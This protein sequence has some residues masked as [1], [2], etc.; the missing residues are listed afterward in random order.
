MS[1]NI[2]TSS[3]TS[4]LPILGLTIDQ[5]NQLM[6]LLKSNSLN[7]ANHTSKKNLL[8][9]TWIANSKASNHM[10]ELETLLDDI[11]PIYNHTPINIPNGNEFHVI[12]VGSTTF[13]IS[14][15]FTLCF[16]I[17]LKKYKKIKKICSL[18]ICIIFSNF[19]VFLKEFK[20][21][22]QCVQLLTPY[23]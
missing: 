22:F 9:H 13:V 1:N 21:S 14:Q 3:E 7:L 19:N 4:F 16:Y 10:V 5:Y 23:F 17:C 6:Q 8:T 18:C 15:F 2:V 20:I 12:H 11:Q